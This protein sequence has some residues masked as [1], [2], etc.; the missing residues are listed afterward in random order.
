MRA[1]LPPRTALLVA[2]LAALAGVA[3][4]AEF[5]VVQRNQEFSLRDLQVR[6]GDRVTFINGDTVTHN[7]YSE[8]EGMEFEIELQPPGR[9]D[10]ITFARP[11]TA[12]VRC[13]IHSA[14]KLRVDVKP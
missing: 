9:S 8:S 6:V 14:M 1:H 7:L 12:E 13:A 11:G 2:A 4:A 10:T 3:L 5:T